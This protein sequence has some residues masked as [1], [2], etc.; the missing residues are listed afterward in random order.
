MKVKTTYLQ[1]FGRPQ[2]VVAPPREG[3]AVVHVQKPTV[4]ASLLHDPRLE[5][6]VLTVG[7]VPAPCT[8]P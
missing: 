8:A 2:R 4:L 3:L 5:V 1:M 6:H 7:G